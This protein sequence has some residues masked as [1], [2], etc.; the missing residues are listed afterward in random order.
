MGTLITLA[1][2]VAADGHMTWL[3]GAACRDIDPETF[4]PVGVT[5]PALDQID[6]AKAVCARC[7]VR[8]SCLEWA[9]TSGADMGYGVWGGLTESERAAIKRRK[10]RTKAKQPAASGNTTRDRKSA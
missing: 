8:S 5:G 6:E 3:H 7:P 9:L 10:S 1:R 2:S 4:Y